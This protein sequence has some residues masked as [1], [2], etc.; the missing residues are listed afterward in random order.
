MEPVTVE[1]IKG[2]LY[3]PP[4]DSHKGQNGKLLLIGGSKLFHAA[5]LWALKVS[6][7]IVDMVY[8]ASVEENNRIV[9][10]A[11]K[12]FRHGIVISREKIEEYINEA[13]CVLIGPGLPREEGVQI[14]DDD[15]YQL[16]KRL[17]TKYRDK[18]WVIDGG[19]LQEM[20]P[21]W[22][23]K[24][25]ILT[26]H[27]GEYARLFGQIKHFNNIYYY[28]KDKQAAEMI[29]GRIKKMA[30]KYNCV[31]LLKG[32][33]DVV[34]SPTDCYLVKGGNAGMTK[35]GTGDVLAGL[36]A[37]FY[38]KNDAFLSAIAASFIN[39]KAGEA[40]FAKVG[41]YYNTSD[42]VDEIPRVMK[43]LLLNIK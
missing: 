22:I 23:P 12:E 41:Y 24:G 5:S 6:S 14:G 2:K 17:L 29:V 37:A 18:R 27:R 30:A 32:K 19:S 15:T 34:C 42:L 40:L 28:S 26:P 10:Q 3:L 43:Q 11:K 38:C 31:I 7:R 20:E 39:K 16:T 1:D 4:A 21:A 33:I 25:A 8:Y 35:G 9:Q 36:V 13:D